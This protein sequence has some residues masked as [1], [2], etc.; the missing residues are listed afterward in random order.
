MLRPGS[1]VERASLSPGIRRGQPGKYA[2][3]IL[4][5]KHQRIAVT[6]SVASSKPSEADAYLAAALLWFTRISERY[7][8]PYIQQLWLIV[9][10][11]IIKSL[12]TRIALLRESLREAIV[13]Y[14]VDNAWTVL[15]EVLCPARKE[16]WKKRLA[17]FPPGF[18]LRSE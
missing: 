8:S 2:R 12:T 9:E 16:L 10:K 1:K 5:Q 7:R 3:I 14:E 18:D 13:V 17:R 6:G 4:W 15:T 11:E